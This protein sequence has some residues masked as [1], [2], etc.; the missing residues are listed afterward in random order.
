MFLSKQSLLQ[1]SR[2]MRQLQYRSQSQELISCPL[3]LMCISVL[4]VYDLF[5]SNSGVCLP[6]P[7]SLLVYPVN[8]IFFC[9]C[10]PSSLNL[11]ASSRQEASHQ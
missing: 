2:G 10:S 11:L 9:F 6:G 7:S 8:S 1:C 3:C 4:L 5:A